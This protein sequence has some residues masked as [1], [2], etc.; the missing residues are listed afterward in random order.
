MSLEGQARFDWELEGYKR[1]ARI[2]AVI[3]AEDDFDRLMNGVL[4]A[5]KEVMTCEIGT[6]FLAEEET[7][8]LILSAASTRREVRQEVQ[9]LRVPKGQGISGWSFAHRQSVLVRDAQNDPRF[10]RKADEKSGFVTRSV[11]T[12]PLITRDRCIGVLQALNPEDRPFFEEFEMPVFEAYAAMAATALENLRLRGVEAQKQKTEQELH[13]ARQIQINLLPQNV[14]HGLCCDLASVYEPNRAVGGDFYD[15]FRFDGARSGAVIGDVSGK[16]VPAALY[17]AQCLNQIRFACKFMD[18]PGRILSSVN[19]SLAASSLNGFFATALCCF[20]HHLTNEMVFASAGHLPPLLY[21][22]GEV[23]ELDLPS[24]LPLGVMEETRYEEHRVRIE[25]GSLLL[26][27]TDG[28]VETRNPAKED[29]GLERVRE[30]MLRLGPRPQQVV[31]AIQKAAQDFMDGAPS[32]DDFTL[33]AIAPHEPGEAVKTFEFPCSPAHFAQARQFVREILK[34]HPFDEIVANQI[35][36][37]I[38]E[39]LTNIYRYAYCEDCNQTVRLSIE[40]AEGML[41]FYLV[42]QGQAADLSKVRSRSLDEI[43]PGGLGVFLMS[44][45]MDDV[46]LIP[47]SS[48]VGNLLV[49]KKKIPTASG[50]PI[51]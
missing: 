29:F 28:L 38:D 21:S 7:G 33:L 44:T 42:D 51:R 31:E 15:F 18:S 14:V 23:R 12:V 11:L 37:A 40:A 17:M 48:G 45:V 22:G 20:A 9:R 19:E 26:F 36:L 50:D 1:L 46:K 5:A 3:N 8:D 13:I 39:A 27:Y 25:P 6:L 47:S 24:G 49:M 4:T 30:I 34:P 35:V 43:R 2:N 32:H 10:Y 16:G 41:V